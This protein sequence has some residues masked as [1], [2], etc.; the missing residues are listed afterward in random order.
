MRPP[1]GFMPG[2]TFQT[3]VQGRGYSKQSTVALLNQGD[4][5]ESLEKLRWQGFAGQSTREERAPDT[6]IGIFLSLWLN[7]MLCLYKVKFQE[8]GKEQSLE[9]DE[10]NNFKNSHRAERYYSSD[11]PK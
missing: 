11:Y 5:D 8:V 9:R 1:S 7:I 6:C 10:L 2:G 3:A 4:G